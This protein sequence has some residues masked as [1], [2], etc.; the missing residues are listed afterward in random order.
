MDAMRLTRRIIVLVGLGLCSGAGASGQL[1]PAPWTKVVA[2]YKEPRQFEWNVQSNRTAFDFSTVILSHRLETR[3]AKG[4]VGFSTEGLRLK[5]DLSCDGEPPVSKDL[6]LPPRQYGP[7]N[8]K[9]GAEGWICD[10]RTGLGKAFGTLRA[11]DYTIRVAI[12]SDSIQLDGVN[13]S[14]DEWLVG[15][16]VDLRIAKLDESKVEPPPPSNVTLTL[17]TGGWP[18]SDRFWSA[19]VFNGEMNPIE[20]FGYTNGRAFGPSDHLLCPSG[21]GVFTP[22]NGWTDGARGICGTGMGKVR[23]PPG[24]S[25]AIYFYAIGDYK[26]VYRYVL[27]YTL[28]GEGDGERKQ[29]R[30]QAFAVLDARIRLISPEPNAR[31]E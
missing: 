20:I 16:T 9:I 26:G 18:P 28:D 27:D 5:F 12:K 29:T 11:G 6:H 8:G 7:L 30:S 15:P 22:G 3:I 19:V 31:P 14:K 1:L 23:I 2:A 17:E 10:F 4:K 21:T 13:L 24:K 25:Q